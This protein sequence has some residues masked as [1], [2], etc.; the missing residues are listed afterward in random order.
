MRHQHLDEKN[1]TISLANSPMVG[2]TP[3]GGISMADWYTKECCCTELTLTASSLGF[4]CTMQWSRHESLKLYWRARAPVRA[5]ATFCCWHAKAAADAL[6]A[7]EK[8]FAL[9]DATVMMFCSKTV[10]AF[11]GT[12][13]CVSVNITTGSLIKVWSVENDATLLLIKVCIVTTS[14][15]LWSY[16]R[17]KVSKVHFLPA[18]SRCW[19]LVSLR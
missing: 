4:E 3:P 8:F 7:S 19:I 14:W 5:S 2:W 13:R 16:V 15:D 11:M 9:R 17:R 1:D 6:M 12:T 10:V 18:M